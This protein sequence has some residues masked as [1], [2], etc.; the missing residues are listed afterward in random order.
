MPNRDFLD[1]RVRQ[2]PA[3]AL[4]VL[5]PIARRYGYRHTHCDV[6]RFAVRVATVLAQ[7]SDQTPAAELWARVRPKPPPQPASGPLGDFP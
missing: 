2:L 6:L 1:V 3:E 5:R 4:D 7:A